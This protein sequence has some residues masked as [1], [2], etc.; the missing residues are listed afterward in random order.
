MPTVRWG[1]H[2]GRVG[3]GPWGDIGAS[4]WI[5]CTELC[6]SA[7][8]DQI[9]V[10]ESTEALLVGETH[11]FTLQELGERTLRDVDRPMRVFE[12]EP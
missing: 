1:I 9:L 4:S 2:S 6:M 7:E 3:A 5:R 12:L 10:S 8:P 11:D